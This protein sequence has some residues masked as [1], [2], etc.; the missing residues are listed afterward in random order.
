MDQVLTHVTSAGVSEAA[1]EEAAKEFA[2]SEFVFRTASIASNQCV[3]QNCSDLRVH[4]SVTTRWN[5]GVE[6]NV[7]DCENFFATE[8]EKFCSSPLMVQLIFFEKSH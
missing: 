8:S 7:P 2:E 6:L 1:Y 5:A 4:T 3:E